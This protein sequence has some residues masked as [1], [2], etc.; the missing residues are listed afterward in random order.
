M[1]LKDSPSHESTISRLS[2]AGNDG[3]L[4]RDQ[5]FASLTTTTSQ[6]EC[7]SCADHASNALK[8]MQTYFDNQQLC[9]VI[10]IAGNDGKR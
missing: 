9:D 7:F 6:D 3:S 1:S 5:S 4:G 10:L 8:Q 2:Y